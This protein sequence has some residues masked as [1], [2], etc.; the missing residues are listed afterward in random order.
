MKTL[1]RISL[2]L[3]AVSLASLCWGQDLPPGAGRETLQKV[4]T[5]CHDIE[6]IPRLRY[7]REDW[8]NLVYSMKDMGADATGPEL[9]QIVDY[10]AKNFGKTA[11]AASAGA[12]ADAAMKV[13]VNSATAKEI[14]TGL[15]VSTKD[16]ELLVA[17]RVKNGNFKDIDGLMKVDGVE[18]ADTAKIQAAKDKIAF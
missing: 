2:L 18:A 4:C 15:G 8:S 14:E 5:Q 1:A 3:L 12:T 7:S 17:Y 6:S 13:N 9:E 11:P 16:S 10:L